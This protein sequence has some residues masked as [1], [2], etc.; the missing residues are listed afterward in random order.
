MR[1]LTATLT[2]R[3][4]GVAQDTSSGSERATML[5]TNAKSY[6]SDRYVTGSEGLIPVLAA[7][8]PSLSKVLLDAERITSATNTV[9]NQ[10]VGPIFRAKTFPENVTQSAIELLQG[11][12]KINEAS[13]T[14]KRDIAE[15]FTDSRFF[16]TPLSLARDGWLP[17]L[18][19]WSL[20]DKERMP[21]LLSRLTSPASAGVLG[22]GASS[23]RIEADRRTQLNL[24]RIALLI[25]A[26]I[27]DTYVVNLGSLQDKIID[28]LNATTTSSPS[29]VTRAE[30]YM[31]IRALVLKISP[32]HLAPLWPTINSE[33]F[34]AISAAYP[35]SD[36]EIVNVTCLLQ[37]CKLLDTLLMLELDEFQMQEWLFISDTTDAVYR[38]PN[39]PSVALVDDLTEAL[40]EQ[41][42]QASGH[43]ATDNSSER[44]KPILT[45]ALTKDVAKDK[46]L[47]KVL[48]PFFRQLSIH[49]FE[50]TYGMQIPDMEACFDELMADLFD[51]STLV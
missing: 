10:V 42:S 29:F 13:K 32:V 35:T 20:G 45:T 37:A 24:R 19:S 30:I 43:L 17:I 48:R 49:A 7:I 38:P 3:P 15:A 44:R 16:S 25:L 4:M 6:L 12:S 9:S 36:S 23:A 50:S 28:L 34:D 33:L 51:T 18:R 1:L 21:E 39:L 22:I 31:V 26:A 14:V 11:L 5:E 41:K 2:I 47:D 40:D 8:T 27:D 46:I